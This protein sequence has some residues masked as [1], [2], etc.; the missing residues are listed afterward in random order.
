MLT[1]ILYYYSNLIVN[2]DIV[3][4][5]YNFKSYFEIDLIK[6]ILLK[7]AFIRSTGETRKKLK[8]SFSLEFMTFTQFFW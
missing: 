1:F 6:I 8:R 7:L 2:I 5:L 3:F 4:S